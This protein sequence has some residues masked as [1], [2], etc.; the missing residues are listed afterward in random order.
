MN[1]IDTLVEDVLR[2]VHTSPEDRQRIEA[3][4]RAHF[5]AATD[6][7]KSASET[8]ARMGSA[9]EIA[10]ELMS[11]VGLRYASFWQR[12]AAFAIDMVILL[13]AAGILAI[14]TATLSNFPETVVPNTYGA[15]N[16]WIRTVVAGVWIV[17]TIISGVGTV[18][19]VVLYFPILEGRFGQT[20]GKRLL[21]LRVLK[22]DGLPIGYKEAV[23][24]RLSFYFEFFALD[25][26]FALF[27]GK[28]QR[29]M[30]IVARTVVIAER[31]T[32]HRPSG[33]RNDAASRPG[34][35]PA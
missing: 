2:L 30:D 1:G 25:G 32:S 23:L 14:L 10:R 5:Q 28:R 21:G 8:L 22:E 34:L 3:D 6:S 12:L 17:L 11:Q 20:P 35:R 7:G 19:V 15:E 24:R 9:Q 33:L 27:T 16:D 26:L 13:S 4:L 31:A 18:G 29:A